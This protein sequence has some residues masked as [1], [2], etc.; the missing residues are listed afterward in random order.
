MKSGVT[1]RL[2]GMICREA[3]DQ[4][5]FIGNGP[6][7]EFMHYDWYP[8]DVA[9]ALNYLHSLGHVRHDRIMNDSGIWHDRFLVTLTAESLRQLELLRHEFPAGYLKLAIDHVKGLGSL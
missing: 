7:F 9:H 6:T 2:S 4:Y 8:F 1:P 5:E 3:E